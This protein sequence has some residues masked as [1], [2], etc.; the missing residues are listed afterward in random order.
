MVREPPKKV[1]IKPKPNLRPLPNM[2]P[3]PLSQNPSNSSA[4]APQLPKSMEAQSKGDFNEN[5]TQAE[6]AALNEVQNLLGQI[7][8]GP[9]KAEAS[10]PSLK[11]VSTV[12]FDE[13]VP[14]GGLRLVP[15]VRLKRRL[16][17][18]VEA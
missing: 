3:Q 15:L 11:P 9:I 17:V 5:S 7:A 8:P 14:S 13:V 1:A 12:R 6:T 18:K 10:D 2:P 4:Q 16:E